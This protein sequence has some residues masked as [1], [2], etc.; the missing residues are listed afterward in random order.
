M[1]CRVVSIASEPFHTPLHNPFVTSQ[2]SAVAAK[3]D[4]LRAEI[5]L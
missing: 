4:T 1:P 3:A 2:G 5:A